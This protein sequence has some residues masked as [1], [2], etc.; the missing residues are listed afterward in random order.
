MY[1]NL[2][3]VLL[4]VVGYDCPLVVGEERVLKILLS[5][6]KVWCVFMNKKWILFPLRLS[7]ACMW[8]I[9]RIYCC[10]ETGITI[11]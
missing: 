1:S 11:L 3:K 9:E 6:F 2:R 8:I 5:P 10:L 7:E 4:G